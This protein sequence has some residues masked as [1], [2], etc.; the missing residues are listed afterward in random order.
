MKGI[1]QDKRSVRGGVTIIV[2]LALVTMFALLGLVFDVGYGYYIKQTAQGAADAAALA[3]VVAAE[4]TG[5]ALISCNPVTLCQTSYVCPA[6]PTNLTNFGTGCLYAKQNGFTTAGKQTVTI[7]GGM[8][9]PSSVSGMTN[10]RY[11]VQVETRQIMG[12]TFLN[13]VGATSADVRARATAV[14]TGMGDQV[15]IYVMDPSSSSA[16]TLGGSA[17]V[18]TN[19]AM[20]VNSSSATAL[21]GTGSAN[22]STPATYIVGSYLLGGAAFLLHLPTV[23]ASTMPDPLASLPAPS[24]GACDHTSFSSNGGTV[25]L[26]PGVYCNGISITNGTA[27]F[28]P[29]TY[30][31]NGGGLTI[32]GSSNVYGSGVMF[33]N[34]AATGYTFGAISI[35]GG[36]RSSLSSP[37][38][39]TYQGILF[40]QDRAISSNVQNS[41]AGGSDLS[42]SGTIYMPT[43]LLSFAGGTNSS[44]LTSAIVCKKLNVSGGAYFQLDPTGARTG[45]G[46]IAPALVQ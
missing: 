44:P 40:Y 46:K 36:T 8:G 9:N 23:G 43:G 3:A 6:S 10:A 1:G 30:I 38:S 42:I 4:P 11:W 31:L 22:L 45:I 41:I 13:F 19:C 16:V 34:T 5:A 14:L 32:G 35:A 15:C 37:T 29:G 18:E 7:S 39:G 27:N 12:T 33:Y 17:D 21:M 24:Y 26:N 25:T 2:T 28:N 20:Y